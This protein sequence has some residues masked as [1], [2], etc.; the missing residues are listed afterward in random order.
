MNHPQDLNG[1]KRLKWPNATPSDGALGEDWRPPVTSEQSNV[2]TA[3]PHNGNRLCNKFVRLQ[4]VQISNT[5]QVN[6]CDRRLPHP[7][8]EYCSVSLRGVN[9]N[10]GGGGEDYALHVDPT[11]GPQQD[12]TRPR[13]YTPWKFPGWNVVSVK[14]EVNRR[15]GNMYILQSPF[16]TD[17]QWRKIAVIYIF[18][19]F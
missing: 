4:R 8:A 10:R 18:G 13:Y 9:I 15:R 16:I 7:A 2:A 6:L 11:A 1:I 17:K 12:R 19:D 5:M 14:N 3:S